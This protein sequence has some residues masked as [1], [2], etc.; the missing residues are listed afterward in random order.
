M[1]MFDVR[2]IDFLTLVPV[3]IR[4]A[5]ASVIDITLET[6]TQHLGL[7]RYFTINSFKLPS[8]SN[9]FWKPSYMNIE[10]VMRRN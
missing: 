2:T 5:P 3:Q 4:V 8:C 1:E 7:Y 10:A 6:A 9:C